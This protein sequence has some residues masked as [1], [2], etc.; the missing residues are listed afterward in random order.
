MPPTALTGS[1]AI[2]LAK[3]FIVSHVDF[4]PASDALLDTVEI[5]GIGPVGIT[6]TAARGRKCGRCWQYREEIAQEGGLCTR[7]DD[8]VSSLS[9]AEM[10]TA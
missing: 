2:D 5:E 9:V 7:C 8:V 4:E 1:L 6:M 3:L 10:P